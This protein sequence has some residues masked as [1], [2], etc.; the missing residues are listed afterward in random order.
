MNNRNNTA[1]V[2]DT[3]DDI[4]RRQPF[5]MSLKMARTQAKI[6]Y[7]QVAENLLLSVEMIKAIESS[8]VDML[9]SAAFTKGYLRNYANLLG[10][11]EDEIVN[12]YLRQAPHADVELVTPASAPPL[13]KDEKKLGREQ[14]IK[15]ILFNVIITMVIIGV[16]W[17]FSPDGVDESPEP[18]NT[19]K[20]L[21]IES[22]A[23]DEAI[24][25]ID[26]KDNA[27]DD[28]KIF[29]SE[30]ATD[31]VNK[32]DNSLISEQIGANGLITSSEDKSLQPPVYTLTLKASDDSW[33]EIRDAT[34]KRLCYRLLTNGVEK[35]MTGVPP[36]NVFLGNAKVVD[37]TLNGAPVD[38]I[39]FIPKYSKAVRVDIFKDGA[40]KEAPKRKK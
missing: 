5:G 8:R 28:N 2:F 11:P 27:L 7:D 37:I 22:A 3:V 40:M 24:A 12:D 25:G 18:I 14:I 36:F 30:Q 33:C 32:S 4:L 21:L 13:E 19:G 10:L 15:F 6:S 16:F 26:Q 17:A 34:G 39:S 35:V 20:D 9:P 29:K 31:A 1:E 38:H 23:S